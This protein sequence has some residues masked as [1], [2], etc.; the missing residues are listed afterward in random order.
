M[1]YDIATVELVPGKREEFLEKF[2]ELRLKV[3]AEPGCLQYDPTVDDP[4]SIKGQ[5]G[6]VPERKNVVIILEKWVDAKALEEHIASPHMHAFGQQVK[7][8]V[9][10]VTNQV[11]RPA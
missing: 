8:M 1:I 9:K 6:Q 7:D 11:L 5:S 10:G 2:H 3:K 4:M